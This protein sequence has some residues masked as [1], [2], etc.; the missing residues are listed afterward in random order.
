M[1]LKIKKIQRMDMKAEAKIGM[2]R[3]QAIRLE[4]TIKICNRA[5]VEPENDAQDV[6]NLNKTIK[7][8][9]RSSYEEHKICKSDSKRE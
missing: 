3:V 5:K 6:E 7:I 4:Q 8:I 1:K 9:T 2:K